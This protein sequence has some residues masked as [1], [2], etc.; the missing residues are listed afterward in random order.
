MLPGEE[1]SLPSSL[2]PAA[3]ARTRREKDHSAQTTGDLVFDMMNYA[4]RPGSGPV[5][6]WGSPKMLPAP[7]S[8]SIAFAMET[9]RLL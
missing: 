7:G 3:V 4:V 5:Q 6:N 1:F 2:H 8:T 9:K